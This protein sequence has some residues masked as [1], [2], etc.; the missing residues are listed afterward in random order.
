[1]FFQ[2][3]SMLGWVDEGHKRAARTARETFSAAYPGEPVSWTEIAEEAPERF[4]VGVH[5][6]Q[7]RPKKCRLFAVDRESFKVTDM[8]NRP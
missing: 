7:G 4:I 6:G 2:L 5:Y 3:F 8:T 1:M